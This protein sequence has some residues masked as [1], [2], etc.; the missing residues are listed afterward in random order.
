MQLITLLPLLAFA[1]ARPSFDMFTSK[2]KG[3]TL[4]ARANSTVCNILTLLSS[5][6]SPKQNLTPLDLFSS[7]SSPRLR[8]LQQHSRPEQRARNRHRPRLRSRPIT[9]RHNTLLSHPS[10]PPQLRH[11]GHRHPPE[12]PENCP[13]WEWSHCGSGYCRHGTTDRA[14]SHDESEHGKWD[15]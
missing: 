1:A 5:S 10:L 14:E 11:E 12:Q 13:D 3:V 7:G 15:D 2:A 9:P 4:T 8:H 6:L